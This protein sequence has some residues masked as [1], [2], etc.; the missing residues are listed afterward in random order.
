MILIKY[1]LNIVLNELNTLFNFNGSGGDI[2][3]FG[4]NFLIGK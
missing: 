3:F 4:D 1:I 2:N